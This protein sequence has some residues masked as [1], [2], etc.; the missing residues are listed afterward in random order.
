MKELNGV[1]TAERLRR[2][3]REKFG[4]EYS[5]AHVGWTFSR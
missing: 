5:V 2:W 3:I 4:V 1:G